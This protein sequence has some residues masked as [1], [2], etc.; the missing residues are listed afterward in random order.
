MVK[1]VV[2][3]CESSVV[4]NFVEV[5]RVKE[6]K[7]FKIV[8]VVK[9]KLNYSVSMVELDIDVIMIGKKKIFYLVKVIYFILVWI[10]SC[11]CCE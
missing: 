3:K 9:C 6:K 8:Y 10:G 5:K 1:I 7:I 2:W 11:V 4:F